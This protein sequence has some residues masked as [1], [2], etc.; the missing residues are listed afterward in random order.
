MR[1]RI[2]GG[3]RRAAVPAW[4]LFALQPHFHLPSCL[5][6]YDESLVEGVVTYIVLGW[7]I[8]HAWQSYMVAAIS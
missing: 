1:R 3:C 6:S 7:A 2:L 5:S 4:S 8:V